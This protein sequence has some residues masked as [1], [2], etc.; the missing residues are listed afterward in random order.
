LSLEA[1]LNL[2]P[3]ENL[4]EELLASHRHRYSHGIALGDYHEIFLVRR[5]A[6]HI[7]VDI[8][9]LSFLASSSEAGVRQTE[10][11]MNHI[12]AWW[13]K[14]MR[15]PGPFIV[16]EKGKVVSHAATI[17][18]AACEQ[19]GTC[20]VGSRGDVDNIVQ[21]VRKGGFEL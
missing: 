3:R 17:I 16:T 9:G 13:A 4:I 21:M 8:E 10:T 2:D 5:I 18:H 15:E 20:F 11:L 12:H 1:L 19:H 14:A 7:D 6:S